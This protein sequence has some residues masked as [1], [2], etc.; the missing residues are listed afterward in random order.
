[1]LTFCPDRLG[2][3][4]AEQPLGGAREGLDD[5][6]LVDDDHRVG[7]GVEDRAKMR[8]ARAGVGGCAGGVAA[9]AKSHSPRAA[10]AAP[11]T[12]KA[13]RLANSAAV[14]IDDEG[15]ASPRPSSGRE[16][17]RAQCRRQWRAIS[18]AATKKRKRRILIERRGEEPDRS[19]ERRQRWRRPRRRSRTICAGQRRRPLSAIGARRCVALAS[20]LALA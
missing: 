13:M 3:R 15:D 5:A 12:R 19:R 20:R 7:H 18:T 4:I 11:M 1:M 16:E 14:E 2:R 10:I 9:H 8:F 6:R 17:A